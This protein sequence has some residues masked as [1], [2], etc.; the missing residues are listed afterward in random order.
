MKGAK[1]V[2]VFVPWGTRKGGHLSKRHGWIT[3]ANGCDIWQSCSGNGY[4]MVRVDGRMSLVYRV[5]YEREIGPIPPG[6]ELD[7]YVCD[8][9]AGGCC[10]PFHCRPASH[11]ENQLRSNSV[12]SLN[13]AKT[14]CPKGHPLSGDNLVKNRLTRGD[15]ICRTCKNAKELVRYIE[16][17]DKLN[18]RRRAKRRHSK[19]PLVHVA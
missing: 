2:G 17:R 8:N 19:P 11:R 13:A 5:R 12:V 6:A 18:A 1:I 4:A 3:D 9:G 7:H 16:H 10:N 14:H 15:R